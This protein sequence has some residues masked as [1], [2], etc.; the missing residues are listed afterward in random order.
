MA[1]KRKRVSQ[2]CGE[3]GND[4]FVEDNISGDLVCKECGLVKEGHRIDKR[5]EW[6]SFEDDKGKERAGGASNPLLSDGG[7]SASIALAPG[8]QHLAR[9]QAQLKVGA[10]PAPSQQ[11]LRIPSNPQC[12]SLFFGRIPTSG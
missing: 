5:A 2:D 9:A 3:C 7:L 11:C 8:M 4:V 1:P 6:R 10:R 12:L